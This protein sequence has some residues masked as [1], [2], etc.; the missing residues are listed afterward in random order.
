MLTNL[1]NQLSA[2]NAL[3]HLPEVL[4]EATRIR[5]EMGYPPLATPSS[6]MCGA[7]ATANVLTGERY[8]MVSK[9]MQDYCRG[10]YGNPPG[11]IDPILM[12]KAL[13]DEKPI[14]CR[15]ADLLE[16]GFE[17][18]KAEIGELARTDEDVLTYALFPTTAVDFLKKKYGVE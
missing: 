7:Q 17:K 15:P 5:A 16:T 2:M 6:Q 13:G 4:K 10:M 18:A 8:K 9:E 3:D 14:S 11:A 1:E 12:Q